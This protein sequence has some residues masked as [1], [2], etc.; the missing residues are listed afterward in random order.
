MFWLAHE[1]PHQFSD[2]EIRFLATVA[3]QAALAVANTR[4]FLS[5]EIGRQR[6]EAILA[7]TPDPVLVTDRKNRLLLANPAA[8]EVLHDELQPGQGLPIGQ[9]IAQK[10]I[11]ALLEASEDEQRSAEIELPGDRFYHASATS[12]LAEGRRVGRVCVLQEIT[13]FKELD[14][15]KSEF[16]ALVSHDL[17]LPL[18]LLRGYA[19]MLQMVG[20]LNEQQTGYVGKILASVEKMSRLVNNLLDSRRLESW[21]E[22]ET[23][24]GSGR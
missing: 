24:D 15:L 6:L 16:V 5:A 13:Q 20:D 3:G 21:R 22:F 7:S 4:L 17:R 1:Q 18:T 14:E 2:E 10:Q 11:V 19:T 12:V 9:V 23:G 8:L